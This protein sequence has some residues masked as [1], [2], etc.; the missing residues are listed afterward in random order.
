MLVPKTGGNGV[1]GGTING[2][3]S[4]IF[5]ATKIG[6]DTTLAQIIR[7]V[8]E[9]QNSKAPVQ[10]LADVIAGILFRSSSESQR[11]LLSCG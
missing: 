3:G 5:D 9:A 1:I 10:R 11:S 6:A 7:R 2:S 8:E 4:L